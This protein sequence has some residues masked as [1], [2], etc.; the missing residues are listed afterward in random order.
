[1]R[2]G[3]AGAVGPNQPE[4]LAA[5]DRQAEAVDRSDVGEPF[6]EALDP[7]E[8]HRLG[9]GLPAGKAWSVA[10][11]GMPGTSSWVGFSMSILMR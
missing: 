10:S 7:D 5:V 8:L 6:D 9:H 3:L 1:M 2:R 4:N 11:A